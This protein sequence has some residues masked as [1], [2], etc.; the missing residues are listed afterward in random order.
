MRFIEIFLKILFIII[1]FSGGKNGAYCN[2]TARNEYNIKNERGKVKTNHK[3]FDSD[4]KFQI[5]N[6]S[7]KIYIPKC[8]KQIAR[9]YQLKNKLKI[10]IELNKEKSFCFFSNYQQ[11]L[12]LS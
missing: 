12:I 7:F 1:F 4:F 9:N 5:Y 11:H 6:H 8:R 3:T 10:I 2:C